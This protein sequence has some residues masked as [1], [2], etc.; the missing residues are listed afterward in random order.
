MHGDEVGAAA[1]VGKRAA[2]L[3]A[4]GL[5]EAGM[6]LGLGTGSTAR[7]FIDGLGERV[8][9][10]LRV[11]AVA[12]SLASA[13]Q[14]ATYGIPLLDEVDNQLD[15]TVDGADE[16][17]PQLNLVKGLGKGAAAREGRRRRVAQDGGG[18]HRGQAGGG[19]GPGPIA[20]GGPPLLWQQ[21]AAA[22]AAL[23]LA[24]A[25][26]M[27]AGGLFVTDNGNHILDCRLSPPRDLGSLAAQLEAIPGV[28]GHGLF[29]GI[30]TEALVGYASGDVRTISPARA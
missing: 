20:G 7:Y 26:R 30:A 8:R 12:T 23:D 25:V 6:T 17:D 11:T 22:V 5:V 14:A 28:L 29:L 10:G 15:L 19:V 1:D 2:G 24:P 27:V 16:I 4:V 9:D 3:A 13:A 18:R 21:T